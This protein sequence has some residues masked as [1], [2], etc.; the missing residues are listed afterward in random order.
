MKRLCVLMSL[1][2]LVMVGARMS[3]RE[4]LP[5]PSVVAS[6]TEVAAPIVDARALKILRRV[7]IPNDL[8]FTGTML[9]NSDE[10]F[11]RFVGPENRRYLRWNNVDFARQSV[12]VFSKRYSAIPEQMSIASVAQ[13]EGRMTLR[14]VEKLGEVGPAAVRTLSDA[15]VIPKSES[16]SELY[17]QIDNE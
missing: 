1:L 8:E 11:L 15:V 3:T 6:F 14:I 9:L 2:L 13:S 5:A 7:K 10:E 17:I 12:L 16:A 4:D